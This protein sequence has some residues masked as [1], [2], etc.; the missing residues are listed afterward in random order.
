MIDPDKAYDQHR[1]DCA[2]DGICHFCEGAGDCP[3]CCVECPNCG[4]VALPKKGG[5]CIQCRIESWFTT[6]TCQHQYQLVGHPEFG[7]CVLCGEW[8]LYLKKTEDKEK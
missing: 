4:E 5:E 6:S 2:D 8:N 3:R 1:Q 7:K